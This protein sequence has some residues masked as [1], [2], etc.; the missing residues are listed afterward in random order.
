MTTTMLE[1]EMSG[2]VQDKALFA[3]LLVC[4]HDFME[5]HSMSSANKYLNTEDV[6]ISCG[7]FQGEYFLSNLIGSLE[8]AL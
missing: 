3:K 5:K 4:K 8:I 2:N 7:T 6:R 1:Y